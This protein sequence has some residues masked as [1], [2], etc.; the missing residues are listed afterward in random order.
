MSEMR[1]FKTGATRNSE[2]GKLDYEGFLSPVALEQF[3]LYMHHH[4]HLEDGTLRASD[5]WQQGIPLSSLM[6]SMWRHLKCVWTWHRGEQSEEDITSALCG[7]WFNAMAYLHELHKGN[8]STL[9]KAEEPV[10]Y[11]EMEQTQ[12]TNIMRRYRQ[13]YVAEYGEDVP[14][15]IGDEKVLN[16]LMSQRW[17]DDWSDH[18]HGMI[19]GETMEPKL[20]S[21]ELME[22]AKDYP[23]SHAP[24]PIPV[25][26]R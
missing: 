9:A 5:N 23:E 12:A 11:Q 15:I 1:Q 7:I 13:L 22:L 4:R 10:Q 8:G 16:K 19:G 20:S 25:V 18:N 17:Y 24:K 3:A 2:E 6:K 26:P 14:L 21:E